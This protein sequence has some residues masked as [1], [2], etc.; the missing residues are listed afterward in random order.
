MSSTTQTFIGGDGRAY[1]EECVTVPTLDDDCF[2]VEGYNADGEQVDCS[3]YDRV[4]GVSR[5]LIVVARLLAPTPL[6]P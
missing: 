2:P 5:R 4:S 3:I 6:C 1:V